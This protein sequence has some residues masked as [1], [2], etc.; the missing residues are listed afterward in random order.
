MKA[1]LVGFLFLF[2]VGVFI[3]IG[4][5]LVPFLVVLSW[6][7]RFILIVIL[8]CLAIWLLGKLILYLWEKMK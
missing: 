5:L 3:G 6:L 4:F 7:V 2:V 1:F 8:I